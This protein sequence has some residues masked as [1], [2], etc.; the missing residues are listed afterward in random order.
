[1]RFI[2]ATLPRVAFLRCG[3]KFARGRML[4]DSMVRRSFSKSIIS[5][6]MSVFLT[7]SSLG[8]WMILD[9]KAFAD[10]GTGEATVINAT[11]GVP[12]IQSATV[13]TSV[14]KPT[15]TVTGVKDQQE[16]T[17]PNL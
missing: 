8:S 6:L 4:C 12:P 2:Q 5:L 13:L 16:V 11:Y 14:Y 15:I 9:Q 1:M 3:F 17:S 7:V 10:A